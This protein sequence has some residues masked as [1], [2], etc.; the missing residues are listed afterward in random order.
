MHGPCMVHAEIPM[1]DGL[2]MGK[3]QREELLK[4]YFPSHL[5]GS[6]EAQKERFKRNN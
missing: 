6:F 2:N 5:G 3:M 4:Q 1:G